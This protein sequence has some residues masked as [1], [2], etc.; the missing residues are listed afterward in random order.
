[1]SEEQLR[2]INTR[3][4][5]AE[6]KIMAAIESIHIKLNT[7]T[8]IVD[9][10]VTHLINTIGSCPKCHLCVTGKDRD[11]RIPELITCPFCLHKFLEREIH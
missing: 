9:P 1:M 6:D 10:Q 3:V 4:K 2:E 7:I 11:E 5:N 8:K